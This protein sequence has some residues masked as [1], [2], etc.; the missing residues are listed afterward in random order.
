MTL[1]FGLLL[2]FLTNHLHFFYPQLLPLTWI[3]SSIPFIPSSLWI[4]LS[5]Y[6]MLG[7]SFFLARD[8][9]NL[10]KYLYASFFL[11]VA[12]VSLF[13]IF[14]TI[15][16]RSLFYLPGE[17]HEFMRQA[18]ILLRQIDSPAS[19]CPSLHVSCTFLSSFIF[20][21][22]QKEKFIFFFIWSL[23]ISLSTLTTKQHYFID[24]LAG[25]L[26]SVFSHVIF[27]NFINYRIFGM[28]KVVS[29]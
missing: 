23:L 18:F 17:T 3:D 29:D 5:L 19:C 22:E 8:L 20:L 16:P 26:I 28:S 14:P 15:Y 7:T 9:E 6:P 25:F 2:Y 27:Y 11:L 4:Y 12:S 13:F 21:K 10:N 1:I 24:V